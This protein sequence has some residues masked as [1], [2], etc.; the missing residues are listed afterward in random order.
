MQLSAIFC[1]NVSLA[2][3]GYGNN[4]QYSDPLAYGD[5]YGDSGNDRKYSDSLAYGE[6]NSQQNGYYQPPSG[7]YAP[8]SG[9]YAPSS[10][11]YPQQRVNSQKQ[12]RKCNQKGRKQ[13]Q[14]GGNYQQQGT[15]GSESDYYGQGQSMNQNQGKSSYCSV[16]VRAC[17]I[18]TNKI[19]CKIYIWLCFLA[20]TF[21]DILIGKFSVLG[22]KVSYYYY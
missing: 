17:S 7:G 3:P 2:R 22:H 9:G 1:A 10:G 4:R 14:Q 20:I 8:Q 15:Y 11:N 21:Q 16:V 19:Y 13:Q 12:G 6:D 5:Y 18:I